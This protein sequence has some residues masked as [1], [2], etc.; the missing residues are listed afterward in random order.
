MNYKLSY[1]IA[2]SVLSQVAET[3]CDPDYFNQT[4]LM[5]IEAR[6]RMLETHKKRYAYAK[7]FEGILMIN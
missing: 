7:S 6:E 4:F 1:N 2:L 3:F 5:Q